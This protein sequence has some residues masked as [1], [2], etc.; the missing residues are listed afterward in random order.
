MKKFFIDKNSDKLILFFAGWGCDEYE[1]EHL[2]SDSNLLILYEYNDLNLDF[3]FSKYKEINLLAFSAGVFVASIFDFN[4]KINKKLALNG[5]PYL[6]DEHFGLSKDIIDV[7]NNITAEN[8]DDFARNYLVKTEEEFK[9]FHHSKRTIE[10]CNEELKSLQMIYDAN[11]SKIKDIYDK[12]I[13]GNDDLIFKVDAQKEF[14]G[15]KLIIIENARHNLFFRVERY[16]D[17][18][19]LSEQV[20]R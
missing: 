12:V 3:D 10:S 6:F 9:N 13:V 14:Y 20:S 1:F 17:L 5:N 2:K 18:F 4:F 8:C 19:N 11:K 15:N 7:F 16:E